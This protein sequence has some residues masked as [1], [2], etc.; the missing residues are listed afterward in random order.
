MLALLTTW[1]SAGWVLKVGDQNHLVVP[2]LPNP[3]SQNGLL[4]FSSN[5]DKRGVDDP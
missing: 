1:S 4:P 2:L 5:L 3:T